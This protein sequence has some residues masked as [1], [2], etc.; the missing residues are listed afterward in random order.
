MAVNDGKSPR[1]SPEDR[2]L[3]AATL[4]GDRSAYAE[5]YDRY[6]RLIRAVCYDQTHDLTEAQD[7]SQEVFLRGYRNLNDLRRHDRFAAWLVATAKAVCREWRR[8]QQRE[9]RRHE[10]FA[11][12]NPAGVDAPGDDG[13]VGELHAALLRLPQKER[14]A[15]HAFYLLEQS[16]DAARAALGLSRSGLYKVLERA[17]NRLKG[18]MQEHS[19]TLP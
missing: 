8:K 17:R 10:E 15:I 5:L 1:A 19:E 6:A 7:L 16:P 14:L 13:V 11:K 12:R 3:V 18:L 9:K 2:V 4:S